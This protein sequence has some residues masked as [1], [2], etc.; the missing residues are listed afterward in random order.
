M[1]IL[2]YNVISVIKE[3]STKDNEPQRMEWSF[4]LDMGAVDNQKASQ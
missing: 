4:D 3:A 1:G 2:Q